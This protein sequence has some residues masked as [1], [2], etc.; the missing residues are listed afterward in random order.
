LGAL[1]GIAVLQGYVNL[2][3]VCLS[4]AWKDEDGLDG[5]KVQVRPCTTDIMT[6]LYTAPDSAS[7]TRLELE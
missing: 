5:R 7:Q 2:M 6:V 1:S 4:G 3:A